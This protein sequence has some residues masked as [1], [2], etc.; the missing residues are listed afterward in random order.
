MGETLRLEEIRKELA[1][2]HL[3]DV[4]DEV[5]SGP[6][7]PVTKNELEKSSNLKE[8]AIKIY[9]WEYGKLL[10]KEICWDRQ[11]LI[12][13]RGMVIS[14]N[15]IIKKEDIPEVDL[16]PYFDVETLEELKDNVEILDE[17]IKEKN[18]ELTA[19]LL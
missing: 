9:R 1:E 8:A 11:P 2:N 16:G 12:N 4:R 3:F 13:N 18:K 17:E 7:K 19:N 15:A 5:P 14:A 6:G 10:E